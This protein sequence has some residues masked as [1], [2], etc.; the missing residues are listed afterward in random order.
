VNHSEALGQWWCIFPV[1]NWHEFCNIRL[2]GAIFALFKDI[3]WGN[4]MK[5][6]A[7]LILALSQW[8]WATASNAELK[9][10]IAQE[11]ENLN[12][13]I[14]SMSASTYMSSLVN[15]QFV[16]MDEKSQW[17]PQLVKDIPTLENGKA[18]IETIGGKKKLVTTWEILDN[19]SWGDGKPITCDD[20]KFTMEVGRNNNVSVPSRDAYEEINVDFDPKTPKKCILTFERVRYDYYSIVPVPVPKHI[21]QPI[22]EKFKDKK[23][24][25]DQNSNY[26]KNPTNP[27]LYNGP[28]VI[29]D[30]KLGSHVAFVANSKFY[31][32]AP[33]I[34]KIL[35]KLIPNTGTLEANLRSGTIDV[36]SSLGLD[37]DQALAL[38]KKVKAENLPYMVNFVPGVTY[39]HIDVDMLNPILKD[40]KVRKALV[41]AINREE[42][43]KALFEGKQTAAIHN[44][45]PLDP[46]Y[47]DDAKKI[48]LYPTS[49]R[50][51]GRLLDEAGWKMGSDGFRT[52]D[53]KRLTVRFM[54]T[55]GN[56]MRETVQTL[57]QSQ[58][59]AVGIEVIIK[60]EPAR[61]FFGETMRKRKFNGLALYA[62]TSTPDSTP[63]TTLHSGQI[64]T[65]KNSYSGQNT[66]G[67]TNE[68]TDKLCDAFEIE[69]NINKRKELM[70]QILKE[71]TEDVPVIPLYYRSET[72]VIPKGFQNF[73]QSGN[74]Y[75]NTNFAEGWSVGNTLK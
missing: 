29:S 51:A 70:A 4:Y 5:T 9:I 41:F 45:A 39:E 37:F 72:A 11:F 66:P 8:S 21:E 27:G 14:M 60:N 71:Y 6:I 36:I 69:F 7:M 13:I 2:L 30:I 74:L 53:G 1:F 16:I 55:A 32:G 25:Y 31:G 58:W 28:Y 26:V 50:E 33:K 22:F 61:V 42:L 35:I 10:G 19:A 40:I 46:L 65:A 3:P 63:K 44:I 62:W 52:K 56:K 23:E 20:M 68:K 64:P 24:G 57:L 75:H 67:W 34:Q 15:R 12:P 73:R 48:T 43:V 17:I 49:K 38:D 18:K 59:K 47:T 54:T